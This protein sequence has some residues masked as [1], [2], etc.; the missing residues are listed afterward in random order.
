MNTRIIR[1]V[2]AIASLSLGPAVYALGTGDMLSVPS[3]GS[4][5]APEAVILLCQGLL[6]FASA[7][8]VRRRKAD[9]SLK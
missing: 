4:G 8:A 2:V 6:L 1:I 9:S 7:N 5:H 3:A